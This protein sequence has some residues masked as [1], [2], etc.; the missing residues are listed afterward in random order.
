[1]PTLEGNDIHVWFFAP[2]AAPQDL[3]RHR[4]WLSEAERERAARF[5][6]EP[7]RQAFVLAHGVLRAVLAGYC[8]SEPGDLCFTVDTM[9]KPILDGLA[10]GSLNFNLSHSHGGVL[11]AVSKTYEMGVDVERVREQVDC[12]KLAERFFADAEHRHIL[13]ACPEEQRG[14]F[15]RHWVCKEAALKA[16]GLG[17]RMPLRDCVVTLNSGG[18]SAHVRWP[19][20]NDGSHTYVA[21][22]L[23]LGDGWVG[24]VAAEGEQWR[25]RLY[26]SPCSV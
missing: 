18:E 20:P 25:T 6:S 10:A 3:H 21:R 14:L 11:V 19:H 12:V 15:F 4:A 26:R 13:H 7:A 2:E 8:G 16:R 22:F 17:L 23:P 9:G 5:L 1:M 24:A